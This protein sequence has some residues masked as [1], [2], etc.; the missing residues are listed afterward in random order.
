MCRNRYIDLEEDTG[1]AKQNSKD[2]FPKIYI[3]SI[4][5]EAHIQVLQRKDFAHGNKLLIRLT[6]LKIERVSQ[7]LGK[8]SWRYYLESP[9]MPDA[10]VCI[11]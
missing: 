6:D 4:F 2:G 8:L 10:Y 3:P 11:Q 7:I 9:N 5:N 1:C